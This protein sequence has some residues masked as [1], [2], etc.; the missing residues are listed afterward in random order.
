VFAGHP[1]TETARIAGPMGASQQFGN[2]LLAYAGVLPDHPA[3][4]TS[5]LLTRQAET[6]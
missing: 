1:I 2:V 4:T 3:L 5:A 6:S